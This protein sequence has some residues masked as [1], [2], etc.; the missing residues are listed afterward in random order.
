MM[1]YCSSLFALLA[2]VT[3]LQSAN[4]CDLSADTIGEIMGVKT[5]TTADGVVRVGWPR[6]D[7]EVEI[8]GLRMRPFMGLGSWAAFKQTEHGAMVMGDTVVFEDEVNPAI[9][10]AFANGLEVTGLHNHFFFD[11]PKVYFMH[12]GGEGCPDQLAKG[13]QAVW[14]AVKHVREKNPQPQEGFA[15][16][17]IAS[18][19]KLDTAQLAELIGTK[20]ELQDDI[21]KI[22]IGREAEMHGI[23]F[24]S[25]MGLTTWAA[26]AGTNS[27]A[28]VDGDFAMTAPEVQPVLQAL[29]KADINIVALHN[30]MLGESPAYYFVHFWGKGEAAE[31]ARGLKDALAAQ[32]QAASAEGKTSAPK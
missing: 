1:P 30:H 29:R 3:F 20:G 31:L 5:T 10:A 7:V 17:R 18:D 26:F 2:I 8:D 9:D 15:G 32:R 25:S 21:Y 14:N 16:P 28:V 11:E 19:G 12:I 13:V 23:K 27:S 4:A 22:T 24:G 6:K